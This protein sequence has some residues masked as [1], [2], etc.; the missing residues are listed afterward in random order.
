MIEELLPLAIVMSFSTPY[1][2]IS[3]LSAI[4]FRKKLAS[5]R[6][7]GLVLIPSLLF[8]VAT[9]QLI[10]VLPEFSLGLLARLL[11]VITF[12]LLIVRDIQRIRTRPTELVFF[13]KRHVFRMILVFGFALMA[14]LRIGVKIDFLGLAFTTFMPLLGALIVVFS[15]ERRIATTWP[16]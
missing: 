4:R 9:R 5:I 16:I 15:V 2:L 14:V 8:L 12:G 3:S 10:N 13:V 6:D 7:T 11:F 1:L